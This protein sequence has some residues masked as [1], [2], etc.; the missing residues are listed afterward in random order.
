MGF[1]LKEVPSGMSPVLSLN[2]IV[3]LPT[4]IVGFRKILSDAASQAG[5]S[6]PLQ[7]LSGIISY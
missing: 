6:L 1:F 2:Y 7:C 4:P 5:L 3:C